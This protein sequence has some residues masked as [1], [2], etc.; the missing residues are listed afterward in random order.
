[1]EFELLKFLSLHSE[2]LL[3]YQVLLRS[4]WGDAAASSDSL[5]GLIRAVRLKIETTP[6]PRYIVTHRQFGYRFNPSPALYPRSEDAKSSD[7]PI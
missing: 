1:M 3:S 5:R 6:E 4:L 2:E 7:D